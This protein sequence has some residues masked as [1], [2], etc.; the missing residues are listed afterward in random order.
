MVN[1]RGLVMKHVSKSLER[2]KQHASKAKFF[3][4]NASLFLRHFDSLEEYNA[5]IKAGRFDEME[6]IIKQGTSFNY[7]AWAKEFFKL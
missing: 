4:D 5:F 6:Q 2:I 7:N 1:L 3:N